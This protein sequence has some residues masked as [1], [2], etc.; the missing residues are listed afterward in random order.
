MNEKIEEHIHCSKCK[1]VMDLLRKET[2][3][4]GCMEY[5]IY[6]CDWCR[7]LFIQYP[8]ESAGKENKI[9]EF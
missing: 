5:N 9:V 4:V 1:R 2:H 3:L 6:V 7:L 8:H